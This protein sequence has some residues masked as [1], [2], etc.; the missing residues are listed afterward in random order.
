MKNYENGSA[1]GFAL[2]LIGA[3]LVAGSLFYLL[4]TSDVSIPNDGGVE[5]S[6]EA[7]LSVDEAVVAVDDEFGDWSDETFTGIDVEAALAPRT[8]GDMNAPVKISEFASLSCSHCAKFHET[9]YKELKEKYLDTGKAYI[10]FTDFPL[11]KPALDATMVARCF[12][13][14]DKYA[15]FTEMLFGA[16]EEWAFDGAYLSKL[17]EY[18]TGCGMSDERFEACLGNQE[19]RQGILSKMQAAQ[20]AFDVNSTPTFVVNNDDKLTGAQPLSAFEPLI[21]KHSGAAE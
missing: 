18:A 4:K 14:N 19:L 9:S 5:T 15:D 8:V 13:N 7:P 3:V 21:V 16:Q 10:E 6:V 11:N 12:E 17:K 2:I 20:K 1:R